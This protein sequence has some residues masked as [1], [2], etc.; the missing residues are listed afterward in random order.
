ME[1]MRPRELKWLHKSHTATDT[2]FHA[3]QGDVY[4]AESLAPWQA[5]SKYLLP[6]WVNEWLNLEWYLW[7]SI[8][9]STV[10]YKWLKTEVWSQDNDI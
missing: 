1:S 9:L 8:T 3:G 2:K 4:E 7:S 6:E 10:P 5:I